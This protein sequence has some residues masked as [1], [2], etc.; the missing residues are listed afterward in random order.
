MTAWATS[1]AIAALCA[2]AAAV[3]P[4]DRQTLIVQGLH[5]GVQF[6]R[7]STLAERPALVVVLHGSGGDGDRIRSLTAGEFDACADEHGF[8]VAYPDALGRQWNDCRGQAPY[9]AALSG[10]DDIAFLREV[11][12]H[13][14]ALAERPLHGVFVAGFSNGG[15]MVFRLA[16]EAPDFFDA[17]TAV[18]AHMPVR[19]Q[20]ACAE[21]SAPVSML[22]ASGTDDPINPWS[23]GSVVV[24]G[25]VLADVVSG[26]DTAAFFTMLAGVATEPE[27]EH[28]ADADGDGVHVETRRW[29]GTHGVEV[30]WMITHGGGHTLPHPTAPFPETLGATSR[31]L[32]GIR[33]I[34]E[35]FER[36]RS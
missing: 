33:L 17:Y 36:H 34:W 35:F 7:P 3:E 12:R 32:N 23:G 16:L 25:A 11:V 15:H 2:C 24:G 1:A 20:R 29:S 27:I 22:L 13:A 6:Y 8:L 31:D 19:E 10:I 26:E 28:Y 30:Q 18:A 4:L 14:R 9:H 21:A 5:R